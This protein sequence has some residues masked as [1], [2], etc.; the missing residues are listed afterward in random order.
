VGRTA[1]IALA[2]FAAAEIGAAVY[3]VHNNHA[4]TS[5]A[6]GS[7]GPVQATVASGPASAPSLGVEGTTASLAPEP[8][9]AFL[10]D[11]WTAGT[12][13][14]GRAKRFTTLVC[15]QLDARERNFG[16]AGTG[17]AKSSPS[18]GPFES[19][20]A[21]VVAAHPQVVVVSGGRNDNVDA[22]A[23]ASEHARELFAA[24][25][26][27]LP[28]AVLIAVA[29]FWG[30]SDLPQSMVS[31]A[32]AVK[33]GVTAVGGTYLDLPDPIHGHPSFM[34]DLADPND[35]GYAAIAAALAPQLQPLLPS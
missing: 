26:A 31:L 5:E 13:A 27:K 22:P 3:V 20:V 14:T 25:R 8:V 6:A 21:A 16:V 33:Q 24:L 18:G 32:A 2:A 11:D 10:G 9:I 30:D 19:R 12:G 29:P 4:P 7:P 34:A 35:R 15:A 28:D 1:T 17:Y 23:T